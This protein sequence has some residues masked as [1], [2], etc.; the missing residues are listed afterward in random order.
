VD[1]IGR[2]QLR[3][4][5]A[6]GGMA[7]VYLAFDSFMAREVTL[8]LLPKL[9]MHDPTFEKRFEREAR[10]LAQLE[11]PAIVPVY[12]FGYH[13]EQPYM[14]NRFM[15]SGSLLDKIVAGGRLSLGL[16]LDIVLRICSGLAYAHQKGIIHRDL[17]PANIL[18]DE[19]ENAYIADFGIAKLAESTSTLT[20][21]ALI[22]TPA[23]MS[24]E[25][26]AGRGEIDS[27]S[28][29]YSLGVVLF[30]M[31][32]G[33]LP[34]KGD[35]TAR[36]MKGHLMDPPP[37]LLDI[38]SELPKEIEPVIQ[39]M[40][41]KKPDER[42]PSMTQLTRD[43][44]Q[45]KRFPTIADPLELDYQTRKMDQPLV[46]KERK[47][48]SKSQSE[49][50]DAEKDVFTTNIIHEIPPQEPRLEESPEE[51][52]IEEVV[53]IKKQP[54][55]ERQ[56][57]KSRLDLPY[58][59]AFWV[60]IIGVI[61]QFLIPYGVIILPPLMITFYFA[62]KTRDFQLKR[63]LSVIGSI[64]IISLII[65]LGYS[66]FYTDLYTHRFFIYVKTLFRNWE[67]LEI[68]MGLVLAILNGLMILIAEIFYRQFLDLRKWKRILAFIS[69]FVY[70][71]IFIGFA[72]I[73]LDNRFTRYVGLFYPFVPP[74]FNFSQPLL[75]HMMNISPYLH[76]FIIY[77]LI[78]SI[79]INL[80]YFL[81]LFSILRLIFD[82]SFCKDS[83]VET[84]SEETI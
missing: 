12:D 76:P 43:F 49:I 32:S 67:S 11:H 17:K 61:L 45:I 46:E 81:G 33:E 30:E 31:L 53:E 71:I 54:D 72:N 18:F 69:P 25:Q 70:S 29:Q 59:G 14:V 56:S 84:T 82:K 52:E 64:L 3:S 37:R 51:T 34:F 20:G 62:I 36:L 23:Y 26:F 83:S 58:I 28:D 19:Q 13:D 57:Q 24:P 27:R 42:Y 9:F 1:T 48:E 2:Y 63:I 55:Q 65:Q 41:Q 8:K 80:T 5:L 60:I 78:P 50:E 35:T 68:V 16:T 44:E 39:R 10:L 22:G 79:L 40:L 73:I 75:W 77:Y 66:Y 15:R 7:E 38:R 21:N 4:K 47:L 6:T 74:F